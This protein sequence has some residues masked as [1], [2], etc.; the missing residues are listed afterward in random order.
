L[1][2]RKIQQAALQDSWLRD[3]PPVVE[4]FEGQFEPAETGLDSDLLKVLSECHFEITGK[5][6]EM[7]GVPYGSD[8]RFFTNNARMPAVLYGPGDVAQAHSVNEF[9]SLEQLFLAAQTIA[10]MIVRWCEV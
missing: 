8:L 3:H 2:E 1:F 7:H 5:T 10:C 9:I 4:W 6:P